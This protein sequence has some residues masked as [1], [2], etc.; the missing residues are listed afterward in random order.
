MPS[1]RP[2]TKA[3]QRAA[4]MHTLIQVAHDA[5]AKDG[6]A[7]A[8]MEDI[9]Q[10]AGVTRGAL[11]HHF[12]SKAGLFRAVLEA[13][14]AEVAGRIISAATAQREPW[15]QLIAGCHAFL[16]ASLDPAVQRIM[17]VDA[18]AVLGW[19]TWR[20]IDAEQSGKTLED[21]LTILNAHG[22]IKPL[23][24]TALTRLLSGAMNEAALWIAQAADPPQALA[25]CK[26]ALEGLLLSLRTTTLDASS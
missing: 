5:F 6:Y 8:A 12:G 23:P 15:G 11:Y 26:L 25:E 22:L 14:Q 7:A 24:M 10:Q 20:R 18:P 9:V 3:E 13:I 4:T 16:E 19:D 17:L 2:K 1:E 21:I